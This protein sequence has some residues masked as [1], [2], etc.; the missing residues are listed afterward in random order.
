MITTLQSDCPLIGLICL[1]VPGA[2]P[3]HPRPLQLW[4]AFL[5]WIFSLHSEAACQW[6]P[7]CWANPSFL[8]VV[9][10]KWSIV[11]TCSLVLQIFLPP[12][13]Q[14]FAVGLGWIFF[15]FHSSHR[16]AAQTCTFFPWASAASSFEKSHFSAFYMDSWCSSK[17]YCPALLLWQL[18]PFLSAS[19]LLGFFFHHLCN[20]KII[21]PRFHFSF[22]PFLTDPLRAAACSPSQNRTSSSCAVIPSFLP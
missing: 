20:L 9:S 16:A 17:N 8:Q 18:C 19:C 3:V 14:H 13:A 11:S 15:H 21:Q 10:A 1:I 22:C 12:G 5:C 4:A 2:F 6:P 7:P